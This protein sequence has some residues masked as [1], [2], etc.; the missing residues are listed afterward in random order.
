M[1]Q[2]TMFK[3]V[4]FASVISVMSFS[5]INNT[6]FADDTSN[7]EIL[8]NQANKHLLKGELHEAIE[9]YDEILDISPN[10]I[11]AMIMK[12]IT[13][14]NLDRYK[15]SMKEFYNVLEQEPQNI[16]A[17]LGMGVGFGNY[18]EYKEA[19]KY[20]ESAYVLNPENHVTNN[21][22]NFA[23]NVIDKYP[24]NE[25]E[26]P[27][28]F[29]ID[30]VEEIPVWIKNNA[31][32]WADGQIDDDSFISGIQFLIKNG[33]I[34]LDSM[35]VQ[36][37]KSHE[38]PV[39]IKNNAGWWADGQIDDAE[40]LTG[41]H[42]LIK[43]G[44]IMIEVSDTITLTEDEK[45]NAERNKWQF[46]RYLD[47]VEKTVFD[48]KR[49]IEYPNPSGDVIKKF[50][51][52]YAKWNFE[53]QIQIGNKNFPDPEYFLI[54]DIYH[55]EY[56]IYVNDQP[57]GLPLDHV[58]TL[59]NSFKYWEAE[60]FTANDGKIVKVHF[61]TTESKYDANLWVTWVVRDIGENVLGH[62]NLGKGVIEVALGGYGCDGNF[63][64]FHVDTVETIMTHELG[65]GIGLKHTSDIDSIMYPTIKKT[66]Y[67][68]CMLD[69][70]N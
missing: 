58:S 69:V 49:Y 37:D 8:Y 54:D 64:L 57:N 10:N 59:V 52:D 55:L 11:D 40:F 5:L 7:T 35:E 1:K 38:I 13:L 29:T 15:Q 22:K 61:V 18:G 16:Q 48:D 19:Y 14:D 30:I 70:M 68:Y 17:L 39:W 26:K 20:F 28:F 67:A 65:H 21:Y 9:L 51:R 44:I 3:L 2:I 12:G 34:K 41:M 31:G 66:T 32:W 24:Y 36:H 56:K 27:K 33:I 45:K 46:A 4:L 25:V 6:V 43:N 42:F 60:N 62:A 50:L 47:R 63:Q 53:Q 23:E